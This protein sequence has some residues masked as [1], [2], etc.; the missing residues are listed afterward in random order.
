[1]SFPYEAKIEDYIC[2]VCKKKGNLKGINSEEQRILE[3][4]RNQIWTFNIKAYSDDERTYNL[5]CSLCKT[6]V[7]GKIGRMSY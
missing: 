3:K 1:M 7:F 6:G 4:F 2:R 5:Q